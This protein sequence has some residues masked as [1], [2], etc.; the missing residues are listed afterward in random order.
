MKLNIRHETVYSY[1]GTVSHSVN[2]M[3]IIPRDTSLQQRLNNTLQISPPPAKI[4]SWQDSFGNTLAH[5]SIEESHSRCVIESISLVET[6]APALPAVASGYKLSELK[7]RLSTD[8]SPDGLLANKCLLPSQYVQRLKG[9]HSILNR[10]NKECDSIANF[11]EQLMQWI[12]TEFEYDPG[13]SSVITSGQTAWDAK[14]GVCQDFAHI[15][16][17]LLRDSGIPARYVSGYL[18]T[19]PQPGEQKLQGSDASHAWFSVYSPTDGWLDYDPTNNKRPDQ[20]YVTTAWG[21]DYADVAP[22]KGVVYGGGSQ[23]VQVSVDVNRVD[24]ALYMV[25]GE[26]QNQATNYE[27]DNTG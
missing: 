27:S 10:L 1:T 3:C 25:T 17:A 5:F 6:S 14:R 21:R 13:F 4:Y 22:T 16:L 19:L 9:T 20:Q 7:N 24:G 2:Q 23:S 26:E 12:Y 11:A 18:E 8:L 15:A